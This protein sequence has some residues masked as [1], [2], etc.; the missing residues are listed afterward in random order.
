MTEVFFNPDF[1]IKVGVTDGPLFTEANGEWELDEAT[2]SFKMMIV[3]KFE[4]GRQTKNPTNMGEFAF[5]VER[6]FTGTVTSVGGLLAFE[7][8]VHALDDQFGDLQ[9]GFFEMIDTTEARM[10]LSDEEAADKILL[11]KK[12]KSK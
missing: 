2:G 5:S 1:S 8:V 7:G 12:A 11:G 3:R 6:V 4:T 10:L 9:V